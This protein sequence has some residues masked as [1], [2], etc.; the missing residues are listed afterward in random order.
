[1]SRNDIA[2]TAFHVASDGWCPEAQCIRSPNFNARPVG[3]PISLL[4]IHNISLPLGQFGT[5]FIPALFTNQL[6]CDAHPS[7]DA[8]RKLHV[9]A[10]FLIR[11]DGS[12]MQFVS[13]Y[14]RAWHAGVSSFGGREGCNDFSIGIELEGS[15]FVPFD[16]AQYAAL[17]RLTVALCKQHPLTDVAGH[18]HIAPGRKTDPG[19][20]FDWSK[21]QRLLLNDTSNIPPQPPPSRA[22]LGFPAGA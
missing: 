7:F 8:L 18:Q 1:M 13:T 11:R 22:Q 6:D 9:S 16:D 12:V 2:P 4:V 20:C 19:S 10:H 3:M 21:Y 17:L 5:P 14:Q 15:D